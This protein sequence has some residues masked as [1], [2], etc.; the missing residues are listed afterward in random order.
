MLFIEQA[1]INSTSDTVLM[2]R[3]LW[4]QAAASFKIMI[5]LYFTLK[6]LGILIPIILLVLSFSM[7]GIIILIEWI[8][9]KFR[10]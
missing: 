4:Y 5:K 8:K 6:V 10:R 2:L 9:N 1:K 7:I 3:Q